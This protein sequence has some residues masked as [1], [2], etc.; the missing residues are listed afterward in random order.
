[1]INNGKNTYLSDNGCAIACQLNMLIALRKNTTKQ[2]KNIH[3]S[4]W[5]NQ[6]EIDSQQTGI[7]TVTNI[8][9]EDA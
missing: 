3:Y 8:V 5:K 2:Q 1:M 7:Q 6:E 9:Q 4:G